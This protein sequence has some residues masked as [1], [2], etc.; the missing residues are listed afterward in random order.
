MTL[1]TPGVTLGTPGVSLCTQGD[2]F[3]SQGSPKWVSSIGGGH[4]ELILELQGAFGEPLGVILGT[5]LCRFSVLF[6]IAFLTVFFICFRVGFGANTLPKG[7]HFGPKVR[8]GREGTIFDF[9]H[10]SKAQLLIFMV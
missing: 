3:E 5:F 2:T 9:E 1:G 8:S 4:L 10:A 6:R 7:D